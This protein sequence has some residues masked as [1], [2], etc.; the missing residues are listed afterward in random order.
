M[1]KVIITKTEYRQ[2]KRQA[3]AYQ[4]ILAE[5]FDSITRDPINLVVQDFRK[6]DLY[7]EEFLKDLESGLRKSSYAKKHGNKIF[8]KR[9]PRISSRA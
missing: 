7:T 9:S 3:E 1:N 4:K 5:F 8:K 6:T 2:L